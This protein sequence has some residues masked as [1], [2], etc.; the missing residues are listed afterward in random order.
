[1]KPSEVDNSKRIRDNSVDISN[2]DMGT[3]R[4]I[5]V[6]RKRRR[7]RTNDFMSGMTLQTRHVDN[8]VEDEISFAD[9]N[10]VTQR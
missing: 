8:F 2:D 5:H 1:M 9:E 4:T 7:S 6:D 10:G 3:K